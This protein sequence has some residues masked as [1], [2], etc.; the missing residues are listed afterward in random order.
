MSERGIEFV[1]EI[2][3]QWILNSVI[4]SMVHGLSIQDPCGSSKDNGI[5]LVVDVGGGSGAMVVKLSC[6]KRMR[7]G[8]LREIEEE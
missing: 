6:F 3:Q 7:M 1:S 8:M 5:G 2:W 4:Y